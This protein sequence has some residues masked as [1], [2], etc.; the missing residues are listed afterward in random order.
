MTVLSEK[1]KI[2]YIGDSSQVLYPISFEFIDNLDIFVSIYNLDDSFV[3]DWVYSTQFVI[4]NS[5]V[6]VVD[7]YQIDSTKK[8][9]VRRIVDYVQDNKYREGG[10]FPAKSTE[11]SFDKSTMLAQQ[12][13]EE[14]GRCPKV[15]PIYN[16]NITLPMP[17]AGKALIWNDGE[18]GFKN[19]TVDV[20]HL[21]EVTKQ[22]RD[23]AE[24]ARDEAQGYASNAKASE[25]GAKSQADRAQGI[26]DDFDANAIEKTN[27]FN[28][29][30]A[31]K[32]L[33][34]DASVEEARKW[35]IGTQGERPEGSSKHWAEE[36]A[37]SAAS[38]EGS[39]LKKIAYENVRWVDCSGETTVI[40]Q[41]TDE[42]VSLKIN[43][44]TSITIDTSQLTF[45]KHFYTVQLYVWFPNGL[46]TIS[47]STNLSDGLKYI[48]GIIPDFS[49][50]REHWLVARVAHGWTRLEISDAGVEA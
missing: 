35:A 47:F 50:P 28:Q 11:T 5:N 41:D 33:Q 42:I 37:K 27:D 49:T 3:E 8:M 23:E 39:T 4:E 40:L 20:D 38:V 29:N 32:Q 44:N 7:G 34:I 31:E 16:L 21:E 6:K 45:P 46:K 13:K 12:L 17:N 30:A 48:N 43:N 25:D 2:T 9:L 14:L 36:A 1:N 22:Y 19:S 10:D 26:A 18:D 15:D 24:A